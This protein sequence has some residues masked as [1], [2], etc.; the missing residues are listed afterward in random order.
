MAFASVMSLDNTIERLLNSFHVSI[1]SSSREIIECAHK[2]LKSLQQTLQRLDGGSKSTSRKRENALDEQIRGAVC[3]FEDLLESHLSNQVISQSETIGDGIQL[4]L[5]LQDL[6]Q[7]VQSF[8]ETMKTMEQEYVKEL[9]NPLPEEDADMG[10]FGGKKPKMVGLSYL[11]SDIIDKLTQR[12][13]PGFPVFSLVGMG[14][15]G[16]TTLAEEI[17]NHP[18]VLECFDCRVWVKV[19]RKCQLNEFARA[20]LA[21]VDPDKTVTGWDEDLAQYLL[22]V[23]KGKKYLIVLDDVWDTQVWDCLRNSFP[24][25]FDE[26]S[27][28]LLTTRLQEVSQDTKVLAFGIE[29]NVRLLNKKESWD[30]FCEKVFGE[31]SCPL[32]LEKAGKKIVENCDGLPLMIITV[33]DHLSG[34][35]KTLEYWNE[36]AE[37]QN[38]LFTDAYGEISEV[39]LPSYQYLSQHLK[40]CFLHMGVFPEKYEIPWSKLFDMWV[41]EGFLKP[42]A[43]QTLEECANKYLQ[44]LVF[45]SLVIVHGTSTTNRSHGIKTC[46][47]HSSLWHLC[48]REAGKNKFSHIFKYWDDGFEEGAKRQRRLCF[49]NNILLGI[50]DVYDSVVNDC[51]STARSLLCFGSYHKYPVPIF[52]ELRL[53]RV[54]DAISIRFYEFPVEVLKLVQLRY[55]ALTYD[56]KLPTCISKLWNLQFLIVHRHLRITSGDDPSYVPIEIWDMQELKHIQIVGSN[57]PNS[58]G[59]SLKNLSTLL[60]VSAHSCGKGVLKRIPNLRKLGIQIEL[61]PDDDSMPFG[62]LNR[63]S[64]LRKLESFKCVLVNPELRSEVVALPAP[65]SMFPSSLQKLHLSGL[66]YPWEYMN[67]IGA[68]PHLKVLKLRHYAFC[69]STW[70]INDFKFPMLR[71]LVIEDSELV[72]WKVEFGCFPRLRNL[73]IKHCYE[74]E[75]FQWEFDYFFKEVEVVDCN[76]LAAAFIHSIKSGRGRHFRDVNVHSSW[77]DG[78]H[79]S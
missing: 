7:D 59:A 28:V 25:G 75:K 21:Q 5:D 77:D 44:E 2:E 73:I 32:Q 42:T 45:N 57:L 55:L 61:V 9:E 66:G 48:N 76:P 4:T 51:A 24:H 37:K 49:H 39:L 43:Y 1:V 15:I 63:I 54:L 38:S 34:A 23:F 41:V 22:Q 10:T 18:D 12:N 40:P 6:R 52:S 36:V 30:L 62:W 68:L 35:D 58:S 31:D 27:R 33:A 74:L 64:R 71:F 47:L 79:K 14:G 19:G 13:Y 17:F 20:I 26:G 53:L 65:R 16:K 70:E 56:E 50:E 67:I 78:N 11:L 72:Q 29:I 60:G 46:N 3:N 69:G 8:I